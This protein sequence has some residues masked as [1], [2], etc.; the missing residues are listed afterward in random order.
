MRRVLLVVLAVMTFFCSGCRKKSEQLK[1]G[2]SLLIG[3]SVDN[4]GIER[5]QREV[6]VFS[7]TAKY[8]GAAVV[9]KNAE[10]DV[11]TQESQL[12]DFLKS[13]ID[14]LVV[15]P[16]EASSL[17][18][19]LEEYRK[20]N[21]PVISY[22]RLLMDSYASLYITVDS[23]KVGEIMATQM[24]NVTD[25]KN[26]SCILGPESDYNVPQLL[27][28]IN[29]VISGTDIVINDLF[30]TQGWRYEISRNHMVDCVRENKIPEAVIC[31]NDLIAQS[32]IQVL[33]DSSVKDHI[34]IC[35]QDADV[36]ACRNIISGKQDFTV[37]KP[38]TSLAECA[39]TI[40]V[41][42]GKGETMQDLPYGKEFFNN[43]LNDIP[44]V[45]LDPIL[46]TKDNMK[47]VILETGFHKESEIY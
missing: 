12:Y 28:G 11:R 37:Y 36:S 46:V 24:M 31:G 13:D 44:S 8:L 18:T 47:K 33:N 5:W 16:A 35:G 6:E 19:V 25:S 29:S 23:R 40:S 1:S 9:F 32:V 26:W 20:R 43:G 30:Y 4:L 27:D 34:P 14:V 10:N 3:F 22:D 21:I 38:I 45:L 7:A 42:L 39:A 17:S 2:N 41:R 15:L